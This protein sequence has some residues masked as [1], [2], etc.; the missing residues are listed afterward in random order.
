M[1]RIIS[2]M[3][4]AILLLTGC[5]GSA[6][7]SLKP[8]DADLGKSSAILENNPEN[9]GGWE[10]GGS[11]SFPLEI[12]KEGWYN[13]ELDYSK[14]GSVLGVD[15]VFEAGDDLDGMLVTWL[16]NTGGNGDWSK[17]EKKTVGAV[18]LTPDIKSIALY[19]YDDFYGD[20]VINLRGMTLKS[21]NEADKAEP[22]FEP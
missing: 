21:V 22:I 3:L 2:V 4:L 15:L 13:V 20:H 11:I 9:I 17:Y 7:I 6:E 14:E 8:K 16:D 1:K 5:G 18:Y 10:T 19:A 12:K